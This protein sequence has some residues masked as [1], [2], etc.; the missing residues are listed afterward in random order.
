MKLYRHVGTILF[1]FVAFCFAGY[2]A[3]QIELMHDSILLSCGV[4]TTIFSGIV[5]VIVKVHH[6]FFL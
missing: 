3:H 4:F 2:A 5:A 6:I 1:L